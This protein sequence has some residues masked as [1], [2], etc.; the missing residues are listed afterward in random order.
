[1]HPSEPHRVGL[2]IQPTHRWKFSCSENKVGHNNN[3]FDNS[4]LN[5]FEFLFNKYL[6][7]LKNYHS[8]IW[9]A[10]YISCGCQVLKQTPQFWH[11]CI[12]GKIEWEIGE[13]IFYAILKLKDSKF[14]P[15]FSC[16]KLQINRRRMTK[17]PK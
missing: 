6:R 13:R 3:H 8:T 1:M 17:R 2:Y 14:S 15:L 5:N 16:F 12:P 10:T 7:Y 4:H 9:K 11:V